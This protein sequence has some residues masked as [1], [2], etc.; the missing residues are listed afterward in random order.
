MG[1]E[2]NSAAMLTSDFASLSDLIRAH[3]VSGR[4]SRR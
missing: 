1:Q 2:L 4:T 3:A